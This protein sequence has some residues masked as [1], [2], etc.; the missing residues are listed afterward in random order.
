MTAVSR[1]ASLWCPDFPPLI[2][3]V[4]DDKTAC[5]AKVIIKPM[6]SF[7]QRGCLKSEMPFFITESYLVNFQTG[8][9]KSPN[10]RVYLGIARISGIWCTRSKTI[11]GQKIEADP[12]ETASSPH[13]H[14]TT[15]PIILFYA[16]FCF[17][18]PRFLPYRQAL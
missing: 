7:K 15:L 16:C 13:L 2:V 3:N 11:F 8:V 14:S 4:R 17:L 18:L 12:F 10:P 6:K 9:L 5:D 1:Y